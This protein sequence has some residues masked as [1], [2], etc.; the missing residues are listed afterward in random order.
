[1]RG[2]ELAKKFV[3]G[4]VRKAQISPDEFL[5]EDR[6]AKKT[7]HLLFFDGISRSRQNV[8]AA[9]EDGAGNLPVERGEKGECAFFKGEH[10]IPAPQLDA[11]GG[12]NA[13]NVGGIDAQHLEGIVQF[14]RRSFRGWKDR[15][16]QQTPQRERNCPHPHTR[17]VVTFG[18]GEQGGEHTFGAAD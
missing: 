8:A 14:M 6:S 9:V 5:I 1:M 15:G 13:I 16:R 11:M 10:G 3:R 12:R 2:A 17:S 4:I 18:M 7:P